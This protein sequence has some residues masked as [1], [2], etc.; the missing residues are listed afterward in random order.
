LDIRGGSQSWLE[1]KSC[2]EDVRVVF[3]KFN[4]DNVTRGWLG[5]GNVARMGERKNSCKGFDIK[6]DEKRQ[7]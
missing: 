6:P 5:A 4:R 7:R 3:S 1:R 2:S